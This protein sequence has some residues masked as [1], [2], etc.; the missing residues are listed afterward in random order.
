[1]LEFV[2]KGKKKPCYTTQEQNNSP[3]FKDSSSRT[4]VS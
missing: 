3:Q 4:F 1:M 2:M